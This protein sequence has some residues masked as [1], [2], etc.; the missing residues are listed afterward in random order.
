MYQPARSTPAFLAD[1]FTI[2]IGLYW[3]YGIYTTFFHGSIPGFTWATPHNVALGLL[4]TFLLGYGAPLPAK[5]FRDTLHL[6]ALCRTGSLY[7]PLFFLNFVV[8]FYAW[9]VLITV[10][11][12]QPL[13]Y[14]FQRFEGGFT[15]GIITLLIIVPICLI[16]N[17]SA[18]R[19]VRSVLSA[20]R[21]AL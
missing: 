5:I 6:V 3:C 21:R 20:E 18:F 19:L 13:L 14:P 1:V 4:W 9:L 11:F 2:S 16:A 15:T 17:L 8:Q 10:W 12:R 7:V